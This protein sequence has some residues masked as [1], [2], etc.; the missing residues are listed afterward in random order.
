MY[1]ICAHF[2]STSTA[3][4]WR[5]CC[6][7]MPAD[8]RCSAKAI[9]MAP[10]PQHGS[11]AVMNPRELM[12]ACISSAVPAV[13]AAI[14]W[15]MGKGEKNWPTH[16]LWSSN[17]WNVRPRT[18]VTLSSSC[19]TRLANTWGNSATSCGSYRLTISM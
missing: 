15:Q 6:G 18:S 10:D 9:A 3:V 1:A 2:A 8:L 12:M 19:R 5:C 17:A 16:L 11:C 4:T 7:L 13:S 14:I